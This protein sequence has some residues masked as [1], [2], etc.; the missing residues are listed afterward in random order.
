[1]SVK[2][3]HRGLGVRAP[4]EVVACLEALSSRSRTLVSGVLV[5]CSSVKDLRV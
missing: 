3:R 5:E 2:F 1:M 4:D